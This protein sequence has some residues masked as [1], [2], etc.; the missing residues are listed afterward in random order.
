MLLRFRLAKK[1]KKKIDYFEKEEQQ[2]VSGSSKEQTVLLTLFK[3]GMG[4]VD[5]YIN[6]SEAL[7]MLDLIQAGSSHSNQCKE[8]RDHSKNEF[9]TSSLPC[10]K[11]K[12]VPYPPDICLITGYI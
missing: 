6:R 8:R 11:I 3:M 12:S 1:K 10:R 9:R 4:R 5:E 7:H 2:R